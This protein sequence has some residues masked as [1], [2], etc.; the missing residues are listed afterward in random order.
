MTAPT[1]AEQEAADLITAYLV[2]HWNDHFVGSELMPTL[3]GL[4]LVQVLNI[5]AV[6]APL[7]VTKKVP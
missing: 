1:H 6:L 4:S 2:A 5:G 3:P 7:F